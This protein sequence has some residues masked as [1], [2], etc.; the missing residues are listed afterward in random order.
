MTNVKL[1][2]KFSQAKSEISNFAK[3]NPVAALATYDL[4]KGI[5]GKISKLRMPGLR[6]G[7]VG[8]RSAGTFTAT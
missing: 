2:S 7:T 5:L 4:G 3:R 1:P 6:G 8:R